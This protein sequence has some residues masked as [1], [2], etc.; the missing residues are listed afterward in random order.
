ML[1]IQYEA[2]EQRVRLF[3]G[4]K[5]K[6]AA[7]LGISYSKIHRFMVERPQ[8]TREARERREYGLTPDDVTLPMGSK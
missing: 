5:K 3:G 1:D 7:S 2:I 8:L 6:A 4:D